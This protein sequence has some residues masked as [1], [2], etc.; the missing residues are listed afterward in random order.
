MNTTRY[1]ISNYELLTKQ[2]FRNIID[3]QND[4]NSDYQC[5]CCL[6]LLLESLISNENYVICLGIHVSE[7]IRHSNIF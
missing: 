6:H 4:T 2:M 5:T 7:Q 3:A 1:V